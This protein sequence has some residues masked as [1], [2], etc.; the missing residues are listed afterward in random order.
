MWY[1]KPDRLSLPGKITYQHQISNHY[2]F[3]LHSKYLSLNP[4][5]HTVLTFH[6]PPHTKKKTT[7]NKKTNFF[8]P[9]MER[10]HPILDSH[11][12]QVTAAD[13]VLL[14]SAQPTPTLSRV[15]QGSTESC[16]LHITW[17]NFLFLKQCLFK[18]IF[19]F[20]IFFILSCLNDF[21]NKYYLKQNELILP[22]KKITNLYQCPFSFDLSLQQQ[23]WNSEAKDPMGLVSTVQTLQR[24]SSFQE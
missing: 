14:I 9:Q 13:S 20:I 3:Q 1:R 16:N 23:L 24:K 7:K 15:L 2:R 8:L 10:N 17:S 6:Q 5:L 19:Y 22:E 12:L 18:Y 11:N 4:H 21:V